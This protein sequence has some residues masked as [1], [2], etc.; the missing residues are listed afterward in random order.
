LPRKLHWQ[1]YVYAQNQISVMSAQLTALKEMAPF[2]DIIF[3]AEDLYMPSA[4]P[5]AVDHVLLHLLGIFRCLCGPANET[6][7]AVVLDVGATFGMHPELLRLM[8]LMQDSRMGFYIRHYSICSYGRP[9][10]RVA[11]QV[12]DPSLPLLRWHAGCQHRYA[13]V[14]RAWRHRGDGMVAAQATGPCH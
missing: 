14:T 6:I 10:F 8:R 1:P 3:K 5:M 12:S 4:P 13:S 9:G 11:A 2:V 7:G